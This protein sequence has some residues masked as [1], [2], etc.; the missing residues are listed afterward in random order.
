VVVV[1][2]SQAEN[3]VTV[4]TTPGQS[5]TLT[6]TGTVLPGA[7]PTSDCSGAAAALADVHQVDLVVP[8]G[9]YS[10]V[11]VLAPATIDFTG[12][13]DLIAT[14]VLSDGSATS[15]DSGSFGGAESV[16]ASNPPAGALQIL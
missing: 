10:S 3:T 12:N 2:A 7:N 16:S 13:T 15:S 4:P 14:M 11:S 9:A 8:T 5:I 1:P 6:W